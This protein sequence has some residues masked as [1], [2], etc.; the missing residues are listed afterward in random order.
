MRGGQF[1]QFGSA[2]R[3]VAS[4][5][6]RIRM[7]SRLFPLFLDLRDRA[8]LV[9]GG[10]EVARRKIAAL[11]DDPNFDHFLEGNIRG[12][13]GRVDIVYERLVAIRALDTR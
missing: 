11:L 12:P 1:R 13:A 5:S 4:L 6:E 7:T 2:R 10:G 8:V 3:I 9:V